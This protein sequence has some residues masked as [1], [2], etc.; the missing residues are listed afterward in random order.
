[1]GLFLAV[2]GKDA[3]AVATRQNVEP[4]LPI[5][6]A[7]LSEWRSRDGRAVLVQASW[8]GVL[9]E[10][11][12]EAGAD[13]VV[14]WEGLLGTPSLAGGRVAQVL[15]TAEGAPRLDAVPGSASAVVV[16]GGELR[17][18]SSGSGEYG[19]HVRVTDTHVLVSNRP[20]VLLGLAGEA[21]LDPQQAMWLTMHGHVPGGSR[22]WRGVRQL[23]P[24]ELLVARLGDG[25]P[26][27]KTYLP[28]LA[29]YFLELRGSEAGER[30]DSAIEAARTS[31]ATVPVDTTSWRLPLS[32]G[33]DSRAV[34]ALAAASGR[35]HDIGTFWTDGPPYSLDVLSATA[36]AR[37][38]GISRHT[39]RSPAPVQPVGA[40]AS[41]VLHTLFSTQGALSL[42]DTHGIGPSRWLTLTGHEHSLRPSWW[43][44]VP[45][46]DLETLFGG[47]LAKKPLLTERLLTPEGE[48]LLEEELR[49]QFA[50]LHGRGVPLDRLANAAYWATRISSWTPAIMGGNQYANATVSPLMSGDMLAASFA[51]PLAAVEAEIVHY[52]ANVLSGLP[53]AAVPFAND[54]WLPAL[55]EHLTQLGVGG[56]DPPYSTPYVQSPALGAMGRQH[57]PGGK[58][59]MLRVLAPTLAELAGAH[60]PDLPLLD[61]RGV[62]EALGR[63]GRGEQFSLPGMISLLGAGTVLLL[64][65][66]GLDLFDRRRRAEVEADLTARLAGPSVSVVV[67]MQASL[68]Q[69]VA[70]RDAALAGVLEERRALAAAVETGRARHAQAASRAKAREAQLR[71]RVRSLERRLERRPTPAPSALR[72]LVRRA[73]RIVPAPARTVLR[74]VRRRVEG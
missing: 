31:L 2:L 51:L 13:S 11:W 42:F 30:L 34:L 73:K 57:A 37:A 61:V 18:Y 48:S 28:D 24:G 19:V 36:L 63:A 62:R 21:H 25:G 32:G 27:V 60:G 64:A 20:A 68:L 3:A 14:A 65:E 40:V 38:A 29:P 16:G 70:D 41:G 17:A 23:G 49:Q 35:L 12:A 58:Q 43:S 53:L 15:R 5:P 54:R 59:A 1:V 44:G 6:D 74:A 56:Q 26:Q 72:R 52:R 7:A 66:Y 10:P 50:E 46:D 71:R 39:V 47:V 45:D 55:A 22:V 67:D 8:G 9:D 33:K 4:W 69:A